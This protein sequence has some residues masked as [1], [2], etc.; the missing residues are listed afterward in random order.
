MFRL[1]DVWPDEKDRPS[2]SDLAQMRATGKTLKQKYD[3]GK[4]SDD[5]ISR[6]LQHCTTF[7]IE[8]KEWYPDGMMEEIR[9]ILELF[10]KHLPQFKPATTSKPLW[11]GA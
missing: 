9:E 2:D 3:D 6:Y 5:T 10:E 8:F 1:E 11:E 4:L 7:R